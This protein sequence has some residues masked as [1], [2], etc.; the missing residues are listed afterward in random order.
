MTPKSI[1]L[2]LI[3]TVLAFVA[4]IVTTGS[5]HKTSTSTTAVEPRKAGVTQQPCGT[6]SPAP[7]VTPRPSDSEFVFAEGRLRIT[8]EDIHLKS[9]RLLYEIDVRYPQ[10]TGSSD[11]HIKKLNQRLRQLAVDHYQWT[12]TPS[13]A[14]LRH[15][16]EV[17]PGV[18]NSVDLDY[19]IVFAA[20]S[21]VSIYLEFFDYGIGAGHSVQTS[22]VINYDLKSHRELKLSDRFK[23]NSKYLE[24]IARYCTDALS[25]YE[26]L[27]PKAETFTSWNITNYGI[28]FNFDACKIAG[29]ADGAQKV[30]IS[31]AALRP[32]L[33]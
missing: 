3:G 21:L 33:K 31:Y 26:P 11:R 25:P 32:F 5:W 12:L 28:R 20:D 6:P 9:E 16:R 7:A 15:A 22:Y 29:C 18:F 2:T 24:F 4:G 8:P 30:T 27:A 10:I 17:F 14:D 19:E 23:P 1:I 13:K